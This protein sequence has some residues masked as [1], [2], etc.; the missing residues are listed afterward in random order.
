MQP[1]LYVCGFAILCSVGFSLFMEVYSRFDHC[2]WDQNAMP[3]EEAE[4]KREEIKKVKYTKNNA[5]FKTIVYF[6]DGFRFVTFKTDRNDK[7]L[8][9]DISVSKSEVIR[10]AEAAHE[11][12]IDKLKKKGKTVY[13]KANLDA[14]VHAIQKSVPM[15]QGGWQCSCGRNH[16]AYETSCICGMTKAKAKNNKK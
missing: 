6:D 11:K 12:E 4:V 16:Q 8:S 14:K 5:K 10:L 9:Y 15:P 2:H 1:F 13:T 7:F 3:C